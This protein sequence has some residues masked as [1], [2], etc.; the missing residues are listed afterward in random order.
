MTRLGGGKAASER[1]RA[2]RGP[3]ASGQ[4]M[5]AGL[6]MMKVGSVLQERRA[7]KPRHRGALP[8][9]VLDSVAD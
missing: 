5:V 9:G 4:V 1:Q 3:S 2:A 7:G 6:V 8:A